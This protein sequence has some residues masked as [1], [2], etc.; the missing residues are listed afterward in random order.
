MKSMTNKWLWVVVAGASAALALVGCNQILG[1]DSATL[2]PL[3]G[4]A[5]PD[6]GVVSCDE[7]CNLMQDNCPTG[8]NS[9]YISKVVCL[10]MCGQMEPGSPGDTMDTVAC[11]Q[12]HAVL[13][14]TD[15]VNECP[16]AGPLGGGACGINKC[17]TFCILDLALCADAAAPPYP[18][19]TDCK[20]K[21][22]AYAFDTDAGDIQEQSGDTFNCRLYHL[23]AAYS[24][25]PLINVHCPHTGQTSATCSL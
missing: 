23:E 11:R 19:V 7:Y 10:A 3:V 24:G 13:A 6:S 15:P 5:D 1:Y 21:C 8:I 25:G 22:A 12:G 4:A 2:D 18:G 14:K 16:R 20:T 9:E 17:Q